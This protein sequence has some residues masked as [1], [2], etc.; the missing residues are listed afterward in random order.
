MPANA[1][2]GGGATFR[3]TAPAALEADVLPTPAVEMKPLQFR[4][5]GEVSVRDVVVL[6]FGCCET[7]VVFVIAFASK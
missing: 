1:G 6:V 4:T 2:T 7:N 5:T 3:S